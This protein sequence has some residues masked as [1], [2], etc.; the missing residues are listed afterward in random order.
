MD[1]LLFHSSRKELKEKAEIHLRTVEMIHNLTEVEQVLNLIEL[2]WMELNNLEENLN[3]DKEETKKHQEVLMLCL[4]T[5]SK[6]I[7]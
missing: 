7:N 4:I 6:W 5:K 1:R 3:L 2:V